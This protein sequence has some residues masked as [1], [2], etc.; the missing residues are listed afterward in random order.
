MMASL[1]GP[2]AP[3]SEDVYQQVC[4]VNW[5]IKNAI[6]PAFESLNTDRNR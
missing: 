5:F 6:A 2:H 4:F 3:M 1:M